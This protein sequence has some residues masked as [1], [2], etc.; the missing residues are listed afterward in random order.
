MVSS[1]TQLTRSGLRDW[2]IQRVTAIILAFYTLFLLSYV[3]LHSPLEFYRWHQLFTQSWMRVFTFIALIG[4][5]YHTWIG[6]WTVCTDYIKC[7]YFRL[8]LQTGVI[9]ALVG[10]V[11][12]GVNIVWGT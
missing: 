5:M 3:L 8:I 6:I 7:H 4:L 12:W 1:V 9:L 11:V 2:F 10:Y